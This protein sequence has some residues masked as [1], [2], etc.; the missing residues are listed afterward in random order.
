LLIE[1]LA[2][3]AVHHL[4]KYIT[5]SHIDYL[6]FTN[7]KN[8]R[9]LFAPPTFIQQ[10]CVIGIFAR[11]H[12]S[13]PL[14]LFNKAFSPYVISPINH[15]P[16]LMPQCPAESSETVSPLSASSCSCIKEFYGAVIPREPEAY[17][18]ILTLVLFGA[19]GGA[20]RPLMGV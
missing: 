3:R 11:V 13:P 5:W 10:R 16:R 15:K 8:V 12:V 9:E 2:S 20:L 6:I 18:A 14:S 1:L 17:I 4:V 19:Q 7:C